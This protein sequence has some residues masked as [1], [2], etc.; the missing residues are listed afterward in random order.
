M[1]RKLPPPPPRAAYAASQPLFTSL[2]TAIAKL[3]ATVPLLTTALLTT[4]AAHPDLNKI[5]ACTAA[6]NIMQAWSHTN[7]LYAAILRDLVPTLAAPIIPSDVKDSM[8]R[9]SNPETLQTLLRSIPHDVREYADYAEIAA[10]GSATVV[11]SLE[12]EKKV[13][14]L[15]RQKEGMKEVVGRYVAE[16]EGRGGKRM[17]MDDFKEEIAEV[18]RGADTIGEERQGKAEEGVN[19][20]RQMWDDGKV[21]GEAEVVF[22]DVT[23]EVDRRIEEK[24]EM[25]VR[26]RSKRDRKRKRESRDSAASVLEG[27]EK[28]GLDSQVQSPAVNGAE[29]A[30]AP[31]L[32]KRAKKRLK[33]AAAGSADTISADTP[34]SGDTGHA[35]ATNAGTS[36]TA[37]GV[38][39]DLNGDVRKGRSRKRSNGTSQD[40]TPDT[41][42]A[43]AGNNR[44]SNKK[45]KVNGKT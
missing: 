21:V 31:V 3:P 2:S 14:E 25:A 34:I 17:R 45:R 44:R 12:V 18:V 1:K 4:Q 40:A 29:G 32:D 20:W 10:K 16:Y 43:V 33:K 6:Q 5:S 9:E 22:Q 38:T 41:G 26:K 42:E 23:A 36:N 30:S 19:P 7:T 24:Q 8:L 11:G 15:V 39:S 37:N 13:L 28:L 35:D 27:T